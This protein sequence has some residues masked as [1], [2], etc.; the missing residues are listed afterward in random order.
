MAVMM[1]RVMEKN[2]DDD[3]QMINILET[4]STTRRKTASIS[5]GRSLDRKEARTGASHQAGSDIASSFLS[6]DLDPPVEAAL[7]PWASKRPS[8]FDNFLSLTLN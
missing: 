8:C 1:V 4:L 7:P 2:L 3:I 6:P 5:S